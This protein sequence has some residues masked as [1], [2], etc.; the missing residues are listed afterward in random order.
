MTIDINKVK[1]AQNIIEETEKE[2]M[3][4]VKQYFENLKEGEVLL[5]ENSRVNS[6][7]KDFKVNIQM[8]ELCVTVQFHYRED[9]GVWIYSIECPELKIYS[10]EPPTDNNLTIQGTI[11]VRL[12]DK[13]RM[14]IAG[15]ARDV[16]VEYDQKM[17]MEEYYR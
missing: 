12:K 5:T 3:L 6:E 10:F 1:E 17:N 16:I 8:K 7:W 11:V 13:T 2:L 9:N 4:F 15:E 14:L